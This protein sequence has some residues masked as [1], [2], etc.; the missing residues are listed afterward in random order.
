MQAQPVNGPEERT[1]WN[2]VSWRQTNR[3][4]RNLRRR[5][6]RASWETG[7]V[8]GSLEPCAAKSGTHGSE[9]G[10]LVAI[11]ACLPDVR[12]VSRMKGAVI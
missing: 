8:S 10:R 3:R 2:A 9:G 11:Q 7:N 4:V 5:I 1:R 12:R 6:F